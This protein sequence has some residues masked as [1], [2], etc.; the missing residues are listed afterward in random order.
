MRVVSWFRTSQMMMQFLIF[1]SESHTY[2]RWLINSGQDSANI[3][4][5]QRC[6]YSSTMVIIPLHMKPSSWCYSSGFQ[7]LVEFAKRWNRS[8]AIGGQKFP[9]ESGQWPMHF[10]HC[11]FVLGQS[12]NLPWEDGILHWACLWKMQSCSEC[13]GLYWWYTEKNM[14]A[15]IFSETAL[16]RSQTSSWN[17]VSVR[18]SSRRAFCLHVWAHYRQPT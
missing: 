12:T 16:Q 15:V 4:P 13:M 9:L 10:T 17:Q 5:D 11:R 18:C 6:L 8:S 3:L 1:G 14:S 2:K 7:D